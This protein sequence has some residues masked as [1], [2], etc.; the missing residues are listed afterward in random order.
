[1]GRALID[2]GVKQLGINLKQAPMPF[3]EQ[4]AMLLLRDA[5]LPRQ[6]RPFASFS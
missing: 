3:F 1:M 5:T 2:S 4:C 6:R